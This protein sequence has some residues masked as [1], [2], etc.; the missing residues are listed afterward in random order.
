MRIAYAFECWVVVVFK[1]YIGT[2]LLP[3]FES[4][5]FIYKQEVCSALSIEMK[6]LHSFAYIDI[7]D[8]GEF[9]LSLVGIFNCR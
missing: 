7:F 5:L 9:S 1:G 6:S 4:N 2:A 3:Y 8:N